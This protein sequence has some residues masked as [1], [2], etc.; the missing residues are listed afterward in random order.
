MLRKVYDFILISMIIVS[1]CVL[2]YFVRNTHSEI[3]DIR[4][5][6]NNIR[7]D[8]AYLGSNKITYREDFHND[9]KIESI[10]LRLSVIED[11]LR[12]Y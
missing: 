2:G 12:H 1:M 6:I 10:E 8:M 5:N 9:R 4:D 3:E 7:E 11:K